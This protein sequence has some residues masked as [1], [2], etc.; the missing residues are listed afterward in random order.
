[1]ARLPDKINPAKNSNGSQFYVCLAPMPKLDGQYTVFGTVLE[2]LD[3]LEE[4]SK[5]PTNSDDF[6]LPKIRI[7]SIVLTPRD[8]AAIQ[9]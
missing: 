4:I 1:M 2:G 9:R 3:V 7:K 8:Q 5:S 6:P